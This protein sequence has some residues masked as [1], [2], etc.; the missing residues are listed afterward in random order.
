[1]FTGESYFRSRLDR[2]LEELQEESVG[3]GVVQGRKQ[4]VGADQWALLARQASVRIG[5]AVVERLSWTPANR[6]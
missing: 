6:R 3:Q 2:T 5:A 1:M 4:G